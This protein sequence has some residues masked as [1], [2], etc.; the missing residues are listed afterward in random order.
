MQIELK[1]IKEGYED[2]LDEALNQALKKY[3]EQ[4]EYWSDKVQILERSRGD[5]KNLLD[6][7]QINFEELSMRAQLEKAELEQRL[8]SSIEHVAVL[9]QQVSKLHNILISKQLNPLRR[10]VAC[11]AKPKTTNK[12]VACRPNHRHKLIE[13]NRKELEPSE[14]DRNIAE[15]VKYK[16]A[17]LRARKRL[18]DLNPSKALPKPQLTFKIPVNEEDEEKRQ[19]FK[20]EEDEDIRRYCHY[21]Q[22]ASKSPRLVDRRLFPVKRRCRNVE[23]IRENSGIYPSKFNS[24]TYLQF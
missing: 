10:D 13:V 11:E 7:L 17:L 5:V 14:S 6:K 8:A 20:S 22:A 12:Y 3:R 1:T 2:G 4:E 24:S 23:E 9:N 19:D 18:S 16:E 15:L 21:F